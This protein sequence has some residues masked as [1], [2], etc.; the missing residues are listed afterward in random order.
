MQPFGLGK[1][2]TEKENAQNHNDRDDDDLNQAHDDFLRL[3]DNRREL[4][5]ILNFERKTVNEP[6]LRRPKVVMACGFR[7]GKRKESLRPVFNI[8]FLP[9]IIRK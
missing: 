2:P 6:G 3:D 5:S 4:D 9:K 8:A 7:L 1:K